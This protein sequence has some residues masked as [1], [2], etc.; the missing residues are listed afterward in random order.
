M[1]DRLHESATMSF[2][3]A[4][5]AEAFP[6]YSPRSLHRCPDPICIHASYPCCGHLGIRSRH[7]LPTMQRPPAYSILSIPPDMSLTPQ[8]KSL[9]ERFDAELGPEAFDES[10]SRLLRHSPEMFAASLR[11]TAV[12]K[13]KGHLSPR[14]QS[15]ILLAVASA[16]THLHV[17]SI[18]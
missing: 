5:P 11:L 7:P 14:T 6:L 15:L 17:P 16:S 10:W 9:K 1:W 13:R 2:P 12:P 3:W 4:P 18:Q 8:Q